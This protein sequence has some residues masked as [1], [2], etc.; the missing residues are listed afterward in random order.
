MLNECAK[1]PHLTAT[2]T[3]GLHDTIESFNIGHNTHA[4]YTRRLISTTCVIPHR[5][6]NDLRTEA[7]TNANN[8]TNS[9]EMFHEVLTLLILIDAASLF[10]TVATVVVVFA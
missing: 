8:D 7:S 2:V 4:A 3:L 1:H 9:H 10:P 5:M 6:D